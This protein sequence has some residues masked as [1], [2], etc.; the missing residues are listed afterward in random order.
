[1]LPVD[2]FDV[3]PEAVTRDLIERVAGRLPG[4]CGATS[5]TWHRGRLSGRVSSHPDLAELMA[6]EPSLPDTPMRAAARTL[7]AVR[8]DDTLTDMHWRPFS[9]RALDLGVRSLVCVAQAVGDER[10]MS[11]TLYSLRPGGLPD[12]AASHAAD[13]LVEWT[14][15]LAQASAFAD[16]QAEARQ[17]SE[18]IAARELVE[19]AKGMLMH[20][21][22]CDADSAYR[23]LAAAA[24]RG[25]L[26][27][28]DV[29]RRMVEH[30]S[31]PPGQD[32]RLRTL[33][34]ARIPNQN[35][36]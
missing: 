30:R 17:L 22:G 31:A 3:S 19:Q 16:V 6:V 5:E 7:R 32:S 8:L 15:A 13:L 36:G 14:T 23:E 20:A 29:A 27:L 9:A 24:E 10:A 2:A 4:C 33:R 18:A 35:T 25:Q 12:H 28:T 11:C 21:L 26:K 34:G 1:M